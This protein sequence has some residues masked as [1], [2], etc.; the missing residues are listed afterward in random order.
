MPGMYCVRRWAAWATRNSGLR[1]LQDRPAPLKIRAVVGLSGNTTY[2]KALR[3]LLGMGQL[4]TP[5]ESWLFH[6]KVYIFRRADRSVAWIGSA[7]FTR[8]GFEENEE[9][10][11][12][13]SDTRD[14]QSWFDRLWDQCVP[15][16]KC[17]IDYYE[18]WR[19]SN[20][21]QPP[22]P[23][24]TPI[25][26]DSP[27]PMR[28]LEKVHNWR[29]YVTALNQCDWWWQRWTTRHPPPSM[30]GS[31]ENGELEQDHSGFARRRKERLE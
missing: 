14:V 27:P 30:V 1:A 11:F 7:N 3:K 19:K 12:E 16:D 26:I 13:T 23:S 28:L 24:C 2:P 5:R 25:T 4:R 15:L 29:S 20:P 21:P 8:K 17:A 9:V 31:G 22:S 18:N 6:P 10:L